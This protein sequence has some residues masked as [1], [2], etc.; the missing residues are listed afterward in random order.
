M[1][2]NPD[3]G[4]RE[5]FLTRGDLEIPLRV[6]KDF[7]GGFDSLLWYFKSEIYPFCALI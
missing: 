4:I 3:S 5:I 2:G 6:H 1:G 7:V